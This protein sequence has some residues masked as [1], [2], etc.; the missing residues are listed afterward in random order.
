MENRLVKILEG[1]VDVGAL[2]EENI[3]EYVQASETIRAYESLLIEP[4]EADA[5]ASGATEVYH[6]GSLE[7]R[8][9]TERRETTPSAKDVLTLLRTTLSYALGR[10]ERSERMYGVKRFDGTVAVDAGATRKLLEAWKEQV[11]DLSTTTKIECKGDLAGI[12]DS[13][14][15]NLAL[16]DY[17]APALCADPAASARLY[18]AAKEQ[19]KALNRRVIKPFENAFKDQ[20]ATD[21]G[22]TVFDTKAYGRLAV[23]VKSVPRMESDYK[24]ALAAVEAT[25]ESAARLDASRVDDAVTFFNSERNIPSVYVAASHVLDVMDA[26]LGQKELKQRQE[27]NVL[28]R[29]RAATILVRE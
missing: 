6:D 12:V 13:Q 20:A 14:L 27:V 22:S 18:V 1:P 4:F 26:A 23:Q 3:A 29:P 11:L 21:N 8:L 28:Y 7:I 10:N 25:L 9:R 24:G 17:V 5:K 19:V 16:A 15:G 2:T